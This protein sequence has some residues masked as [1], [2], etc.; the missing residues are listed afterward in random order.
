MRGTKVCA[1]PDVACLQL[2]LVSLP[3]HLPAPACLPVY[4]PA[5]LLRVPVYLPACLP[6]CDVCI[7]A[8]LLRVHVHISCL[9]TRLSPCLQ[10]LLTDEPFTRKD[11]LHLQD[12]LN[13]SGRLI[14]EFHHV[15]FVSTV[16]PGWIC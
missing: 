4:M 9:H 14:S 12:P 8:C 16:A 2:C 15:R 1:A 3:A 5:C 6:A 7:P 13:V 10:D 11:I